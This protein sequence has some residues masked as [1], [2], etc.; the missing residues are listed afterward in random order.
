MTPFSL[1][2]A[3]PLAAYQDVATLRLGVAGCFVRRGKMTQ[4]TPVSAN[5]AAGP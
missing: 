4:L 2:T 1:I 5:P 3:Q